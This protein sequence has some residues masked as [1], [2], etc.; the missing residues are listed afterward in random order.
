MKYDARLTLL[1]QEVEQITGKQP[2]HNT[3]NATRDTRTNCFCRRHLGANS[4]NW[5]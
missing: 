4:D 1:R 3:E 5:F 2:V